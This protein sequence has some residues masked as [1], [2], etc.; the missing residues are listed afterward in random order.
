MSPIFGAKL[1]GLIPTFAAHQGDGV[2]TGD[3]L[4]S[5]EDTDCKQQVDGSRRMWPRRRDRHMHPHL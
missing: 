4:A 3:K 1:E 2:K 5:V